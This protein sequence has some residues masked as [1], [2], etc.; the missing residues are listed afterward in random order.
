MKIRENVYKTVTGMLLFHSD[1]Q[2]Y[3]IPLGQFEYSLTV[4]T[5]YEKRI[6]I[7]LLLGQI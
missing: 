2:G 6:G 4:V 1:T 5:L 7:Q 3:K